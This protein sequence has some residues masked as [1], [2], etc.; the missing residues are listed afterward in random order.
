MADIIIKAPGRICLFGDHQD[1]LGLPVIACSIDR[2][3]T[4]EAT[5][6][7]RREIKVSMP[8]I[9]STRT[10]NIDQVV[11]TENERDYFSSALVVLSRYNYVPNT[12]Y[13]ITLYGDIPVNAGLSS[14]SA[15]LVAWIAFLLEAFGCSEN[16]SPEFIAK[17][18]YTAEVLEFNAPGGLMDQ[19]AIS[20][21]SCVHLNAV[22]GKHTFLNDDIHTLVVGASGVPKETLGV[23]GQLGTMAK[24]SIAQ[25]QS[26]HPNF[27]IK[28]AT[29]EDYEKFEPLLEEELKPI[30]YA[31]IKNHLITQEAFKLMQQGSID[32]NR[33]GELID[34]HHFELKEHLGI[35][36]P[37]IDAMIDGAKNAGALGA[38]IVGSGGGGCIVALC[39]P[40]NTDAVIKAIKAAGAADAYAIKIEKGVH[41]L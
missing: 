29:L 6:T 21:G 41:T 24:T 35:T 15:V 16:V 33:I 32:V 3:I 20:L 13:D 7:E 9:N 36:V 11:V 40:M 27:D 28:K 5:K 10:F 8:D 18:A 34:A 31:A 4:L 25:I 1:Y 38:K 14:S 17:I 26:K 39:K 19:Y 23:L 22:T 12:G 37:I 2:Y 30:F